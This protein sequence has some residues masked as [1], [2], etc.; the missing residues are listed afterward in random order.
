MLI[1]PPE[2]IA[3]ADRVLA[4]LHLDDLCKDLLTGAVLT[5]LTVTIAPQREAVTI[6]TL[7]TMHEVALGDMS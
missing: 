7:D 5:L 6:D 2:A 4:T 3:W 1:V